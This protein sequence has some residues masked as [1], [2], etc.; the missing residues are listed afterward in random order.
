MLCDICHKNE[1]ILFLEQ[2]SPSGKVKANLCMQCAVKYG[3]SP[4]PKTVEKSL[5][6]LFSVLSKK[7]KIVS[8]DNSKL[9]PVCGQSLATIKKYGFTGCPEC[10]SIF[11]AQIKES[12]KNNGTEVQYTGS[13][14]SRL[15]S[16]RSRLTDRMDLQLKLEDSLK[17][18]NYEKAAMYRD[19][20]R[21]LE[22]Q[23]VSD[24]S[25]S[26]VPEDDGNE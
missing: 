22:R 10:Y 4:D 14:P 13:M 3:L 26:S 6:D 15:H 1:S 24:G 12:L 17:T 23:S 20:L 16:F 2:V 19:F 5:G 9:C 7:E 11:S 25:D 18:E 21:A 8:E